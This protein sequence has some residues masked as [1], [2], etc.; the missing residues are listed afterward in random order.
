MTN[1]Y[2]GVSV[3][4]VGPSEFDGWAV[5]IQEDALPPTIMS[6]YITRDGAETEA[7]RLREQIAANL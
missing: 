3:V 6:V 2:T 5:V 7:K 1:I 4:L